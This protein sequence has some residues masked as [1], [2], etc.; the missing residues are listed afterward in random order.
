M[1]FTGHTLDVVVQEPRTG[2]GVSGATCVLYSEGT[3]VTGGTVSGDPVTGLTGGTGVTISGET[4]RWGV[5]ELID[6]PPGVYTVIVSGAGYSTQRLRGYER[7]EVGPLI[8]GAPDY[9]QLRD[10]TG[11]T[12]YVTVTTGGTLSVTDTLT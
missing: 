12:W 10:A 6:I 11:G 9:L 1:S 7:V 5:L 2:R 3:I 8:R 4:A